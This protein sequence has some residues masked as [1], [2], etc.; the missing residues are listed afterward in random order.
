MARW[1]ARPKSPSSRVWFR[2][3]AGRWSTTPRARSST[4]PT[5]AS[6]RAKRVPGRGPW[7]GRPTRNPAPNGL[8]LL[9]L[10]PRLPQGAGRLCA[11][12]GPHSAAAALRLR[13]MVVALLG[14]QRP[15]AR[16]AG[17]RLPRERYAARR[18]RD[19]HGL[20]HQPGAA[21]GH[22]RD[23]SVGPDA[24]L[25]RLHLEQAALSR[26]RRVSQEPARRGPE[27]HAQS[28][29]G[30]GHSAVGAGVSGD[31]A[32]HGHRSG[33][34]EIRALRYRR[35]RSGRPTTSTWCSIRWRSRASTS[36][37]STGSSSPDD[38]P[39][40]REPHLVAQLR[41]LH[42]SA[43]R[44]QAAAALP[45]LGRAGQSPLPD[46]LL[47][48]HHLGV[49]FA[50]L[51]AVVHGH[52]GQRGL[53]LLEPRHRRPHARRGRSGTLHALGAV[54]RLQPHSAHAHHQES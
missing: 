43:A 23:R 45:S 5:S 34:E 30:L 40:R 10:R 17:A 35:T 20:A 36:G 53:R 15:G 38:Q 11:R 4:P 51:S 18:A 21:Q 7:S 50:R 25:D 13:R 47:R 28:A 26:S 41:A 6:S 44:G 3:P 19:R 48:R 29:S 27:G 33:H 22:G 16:R 49:G 8:V 24:G 2:A 42:R 39:A 12:G 32:R 1:A 54:R 9:R 52:G 31:G 14:L 46:R 37:G